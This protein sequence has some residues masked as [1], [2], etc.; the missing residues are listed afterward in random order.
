TIVGLY[1]KDENTAYRVRFG[2]NFGS[3][4]NDF[5]VPQD[6]ATDPNARVTDTKKVSTH[7]VTIGVGL[8]KSRGKGRLHGIYGAEFLVTVGGG[9]KTTYTY[10]NSFDP[11]T[12]TATIS[13]FDPA[14]PNFSSSVS[15]R[16]KETK[17]GSEFGV[18]LFGFIGAEYFFAPKMS[19]SAEYGWG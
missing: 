18:G 13:D 9:S 7:G 17:G 4:K 14:N 15:S 19:L 12:G 1:V 16:T 2:L 11:T 3:T 5:L 10:G 6:G 8:Q